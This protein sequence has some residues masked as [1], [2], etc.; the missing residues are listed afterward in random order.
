MVQID[1]YIKCFDETNEIAK[2]SYFAAEPITLNDLISCFPFKGKYH[3][4]YK[5][6]KDDC[7]NYKKISISEDYVWV[8]ILSNSDTIIYNPNKS[9]VIEIQALVNI[10]YHLQ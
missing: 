4:R 5:L 10:L 7:K 2:T 3:F 9:N 1:Y 6:S 8:D